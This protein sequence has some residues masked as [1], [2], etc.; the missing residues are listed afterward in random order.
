MHADSLQRGR[1]GRRV[2]HHQDTPC[3]HISGG[4]L[5]AVWPMSHHVTDIILKKQK[6]HTYIASIT[7]IKHKRL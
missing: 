3:P 6:A 5:Y 1:A 7:V 4:G 2:S